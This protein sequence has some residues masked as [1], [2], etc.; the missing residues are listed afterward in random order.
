[1]HQLLLLFFH[2]FTV[3]FQSQYITTITT[4]QTYLYFSKLTAVNSEVFAVKA[5]DADGDTIL[6]I[7]DD[8]SVGNDSSDL[9]RTLLLW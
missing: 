1:M 8:T 7:L 2:Y 6:Y 5:K 4:F 3:T 9:A